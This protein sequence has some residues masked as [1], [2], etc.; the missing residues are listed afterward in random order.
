MKGRRNTSRKASV[1]PRN[2]VVP[3]MRLNCK[4]GAHPDKKKEASRKACRS[5][6]VDKGG[7]DEQPGP[8]E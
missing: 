5:V 4:P 6:E 3:L 1:K 8:D 7:N 2:H